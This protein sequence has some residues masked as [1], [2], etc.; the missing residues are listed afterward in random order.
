M[1]LILELL[2]IAIIGFLVVALMVFARS[3]KVYNEAMT[4]FIDAFERNTE[5]MK[6]LGQRIDHETIKEIIRDDRRYN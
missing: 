3:I 4:T 5:E 6:K 1:Q 2:N